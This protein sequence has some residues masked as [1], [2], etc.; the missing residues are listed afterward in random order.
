MDTAHHILIYGCGAPGSQKPLWSCGEMAHHDAGEETASPC[1]EGSN[2][3]IIYAWARD[4][5]R[6]ALP[7]DVGFKVGKDSSIQYLVLQV[8]YAHV[9]P[10]G[11]RDSS[12]IILEH[13]EQE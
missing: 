2:T 13:T 6:L 1:G 7:R 8:H 4:A 5:P 9:L 11:H 12:G 10:K 3:Q